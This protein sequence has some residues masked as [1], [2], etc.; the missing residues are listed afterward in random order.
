MRQQQVLTGRE[1]RAP[2]GHVATLP[3]M[4]AGQNDDGG[5]LD[6]VDE[7]LHRRRHASLG[8]RRVVPAPPVVRVILALAHPHRTE[9]LTEQGA[10]FLGPRSVAQ[11]H[12]PEGLTVRTRRR[13]RGGEEN[14]G[15]IGLGYG[16]GRVATNGPS[17]PAAR[18]IQRFVVSRRSRVVGVLTVCDRRPS[19][20]ELMAPREACTSPSD[21]PLAS[22]PAE[23]GRP[24]TGHPRRRWR[25]ALRCS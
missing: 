13:T 3:Q 11:H 2:L 8:R 15:Q 10:G 23:R 6:V 19:R 24:P 20:T 12:E 5:V 1:D 7:M 21:P 18:S 25:N 22:V 16:V 9:G 14:G 17:R 4:S